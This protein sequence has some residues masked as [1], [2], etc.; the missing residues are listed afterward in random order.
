M[1]LGVVEPRR[2]APQPAMPAP[3]PAPAPAHP[4]DVEDPNAPAFTPTARALAAFTAASLA[5]A[6][7]AC[8]P[9][10]RIDVSA[11]AA[12]VALL[13]VCGAFGVWLIRVDRALQ[14]T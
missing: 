6:A 14:K 3:Q 12:G 1:S 13:A 7:W 2:S 9:Y 8:G 11:A 4:A 10:G 5:F